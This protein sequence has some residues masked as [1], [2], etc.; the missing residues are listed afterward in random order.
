MTLYHD[1]ILWNQGQQLVGDLVEIFLR[2]SVIDRAHLTGNCF[3]IQQLKSDTA[4]YNQVSSREMF[5]YFV[6]GKI[7]EARAKDNVLIGYFF[8]EGDT[9]PIIYNYQETSEL[10]TFVKDQKLQSV[11]TPKTTGTMYPLNQ[12]PA[13]RRRLPGFAW[14]DYVRPLNRYDIFNWRDKGE[15][16]KK[17]KK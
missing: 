5:A 14:Y 13:D 16:V 6:E 10:R 1:P 12:V 9:L 2:D 3:S 8:E 15:K 17:V 7:H 11:W 4:C